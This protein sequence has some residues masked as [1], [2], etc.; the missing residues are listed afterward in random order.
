M[1]LTPL[2]ICVIAAFGVAYLTYGRVLGRFFRLDDATVTPAHLQ[3]DGVDFAPTPP[4]MLAAQHF[5]AITAAGPV[6]GPITAG[7]MFGW[8][9]ALLWIVIGCIFIGAVHDFSALVASVRHKARSVAEVM[10]E[11]TSGRAFYVFLLFI[12]LSLMYVMVAF[13][14]LTAKQFIAKD[15]GAGVASSSGMYLLLAF[16]VGVA[17]R[18]GMRTLPATLVFIPVLFAI[19]WFGQ[20]LP[21]VAPG[22]ASN[23]HK[24][25]EVAILVY[26]GIASVVPLWALLQPRGFLGGWFLYVTIGAGLLGVLVGSFFFDDGFSVTYPAFVG[27]G[28]GTKFLFPFLFVTIACGACSGF[29]GIVCSGTTSKQIDR[30]GHA[31]PVG[32][33][34]MLGEGVVA[35]ISLATVMILAPEAKGDPTAIY[36][37]GVANFLRIF[38]IE[39]RLAVAF[40]SLAIATFI[41]DTLDVCTRLGRQICCELFGLKGRTGLVVGTVVTLAVP[42]YFL[43]TATTDAWKTYWLVFG[44]SNQLLAGLTLLGVTVWLIR[45]GRP[46]WFVGIPMAFLIVTTMSSLVLF[47]RDAVAGAATA[48]ARQAGVAAAVLFVLAVWLVVEAVVAL[49]RALGTP[50]AASATPA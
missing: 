33:G 41:F 24:F 14:D 4:G 8:L 47:M 49:R 38:R 25:W 39:P 37:N 22:S 6:I 12:W 17:F 36:A 1:T 34:S 40:G 19:V 43:L 9:P 35:F 2:A 50:R 44:T 46:S 20:K 15:I 29:H 21:L 23:P 32:Y 27:W 13:T 10:K 31:R 3:K 45:S 26:C 5:S 16:V 28:S 42:A 7:L 18:K 48:Q 11:H 30:E